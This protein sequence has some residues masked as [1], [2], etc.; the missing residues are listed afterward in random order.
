MKSKLLADRIYVLRATKRL[1]QKEIAQALGV[2]AT[3]YSRIEKGERGVKESSLVLLAELLDA[4]L[5]ELHTLWT[6]DRM[7]NATGQAPEN[8]TERALNIL[9]DKTG[10]KI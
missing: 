2:T 7:A 8:I 5:E 1:Q 3:T 9:Q 6:A 10:C 4:D